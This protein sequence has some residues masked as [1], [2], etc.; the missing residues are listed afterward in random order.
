MRSVINAFV[1][2]QY[3]F[4]LSFLINY[5]IL[6]HSARLSQPTPERMRSITALFSRVF[7]ANRSQSLSQVV[8]YALV[9][10]GRGEGF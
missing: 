4:G 2:N 10:G 1:V 3:N 7:A 6:L 5:P 8:G 9:V